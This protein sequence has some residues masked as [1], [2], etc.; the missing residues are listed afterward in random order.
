MA[1]HPRDR[2]HPAPSRLQFG[3]FQDIGQ[4]FLRPYMGRARDY[5]KNL[6]DD[7]SPYSPNAIEVL[8]K[9]PCCAESCDFLLGLIKNYPGMASDD[10]LA[11]LGRINAGFG[12]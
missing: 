5:A 10:M 11:A 6:R 4:G 7:A 12:R 2:D 3:D 9:G 8:G 1:A